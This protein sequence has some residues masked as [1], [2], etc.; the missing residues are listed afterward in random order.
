MYHKHYCYSLN[1]S[2]AQ[3]FKD[4][5]NTER[6]GRPPTLVIVPRVKKWD[7]FL[8]DIRYADFAY[9][10]DIP[11]SYSN[12]QCYI[13]PPYKPILSVSVQSGINAHTDVYLLRGNLSFNI[14]HL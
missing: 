5:I 14:I 2:K 1:I 10:L 4:I 3:V 11:K 8:I 13:V 9:T 12:E 6:I 7:N